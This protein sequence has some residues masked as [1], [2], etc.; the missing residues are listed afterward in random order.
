M[1]ECRKFA[2]ATSDA[3][4]RQMNLDIAEQWRELAEW[5]ERLAA[6]QSS[7]LGPITSH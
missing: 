5:E 1:T 7:G 2:L 3:A 6:T 4:F